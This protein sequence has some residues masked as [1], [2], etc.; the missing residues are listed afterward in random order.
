MNRQAWPL[1][2]V[3]QGGTAKL[4][5]KDGQVLWASDADEEFRES[6]SEIGEL[7]TEHDMDDVLDYLEESSIVSEREAM[8]FEDGE[9][10]TS[11]LP[12]DAGDPPN[13]WSNRHIYSAAA[14]GVVCGCDAPEC[15]ARREALE[16]SEANG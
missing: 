4:L 5:G 16:E 10:E 3:L 6:C 7:V 14:Q 13:D 1:E 11:E 9:F 2:L 15:V 12:A 8:K